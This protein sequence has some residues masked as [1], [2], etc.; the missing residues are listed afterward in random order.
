LL[1]NSNST[2]HSTLTFLH[3]QVGEENREDILRTE[4]LGNVAKG[5]D[6]GSADTLLVRFEQV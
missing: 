1:T 2:T 6:S 5:I 3:P 4:G